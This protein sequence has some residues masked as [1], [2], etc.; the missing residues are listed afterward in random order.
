[1]IAGSAK[2]GKNVWVAP[3][4]SILN[5]KV[6]KDNSVI[7]MGAVILKDVEENEVI[8]GNPGKSIKNKE[9]R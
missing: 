5:K 4:A 3:S 7:G 9:G 2:I 8:V 1:M 6:V